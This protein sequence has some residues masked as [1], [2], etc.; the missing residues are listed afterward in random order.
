MSRPASRFVEKLTK[1]QIQKLEEDYRHGDTSRIRER[2]HAILLSYQKTSVVELARIFQTS[3]TTISQWLDRWDSEGLAGL[4]DKPRPGAPSK[5]TEHELSR[6]VE[7]L[8]LS[9]H[10]PIAALL[11]IKQETGK[12]ISRSTLKRIAKA[13]GLV[14]KRMRKSLGSQRDQ[15]KFATQS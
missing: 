14:W 1:Q 10:N 7:L 13:A 9:A 15:K 4:A 5:L 2:S 6:A 12:E 3:R 11:E 8:K